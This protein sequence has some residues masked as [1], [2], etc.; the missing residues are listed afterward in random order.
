MRADIKLFNIDFNDE[1]SFLSSQT[2]YI[3]NDFI[4]ISFGII[5]FSKIIW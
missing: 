5:K 1:I 2:S 4:A 3:K